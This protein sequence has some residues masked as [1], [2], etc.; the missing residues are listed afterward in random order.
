MFGIIASQANIEA[1]GLG[2]LIGMDIISQGDFAI[3]N[4]VANNCIYISV[5]FKSYD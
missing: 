3:S 4:F 1:Q 5:S 2:M